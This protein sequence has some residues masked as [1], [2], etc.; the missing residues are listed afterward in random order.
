MHPPRE[1][2]TP[3]RQE[4]D[5]GTPRPVHF[6]RKFGCRRPPG[7]PGK[8]K[9]CHGAA[10]KTAQGGTQKDNAQKERGKGALI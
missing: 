3:Y 6:P 9:V 1:P 7:G 10:E 5:Y 2:D 8:E 4:S